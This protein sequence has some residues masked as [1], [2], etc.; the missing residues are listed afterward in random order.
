[1][2]YITSEMVESRSARY[3]ETSTEAANERPEDYLISAE[4]SDGLWIEIDITGKSRD[5][6]RERKEGERTERMR[7]ESGHLHITIRGGIEGELHV[8]QDLSRLM[9]DLQRLLK[10]RFSYVRAQVA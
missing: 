7:L 9:N 6:A 8:T 1:L 2:E 3:T 5:F 4:R 10:E